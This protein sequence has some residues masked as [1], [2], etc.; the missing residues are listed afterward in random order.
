[1]SAVEYRKDII[2]E[3]FYASR[4]YNSFRHAYEVPGSNRAMLDWNLGL[5]QVRRRPKDPGAASM[6]NLLTANLRQ[7]ELQT[8][9]HS[10][11]PYHGETETVGRYQNYANTGHMLRGPRGT[12]GTAHA[13]DWQLNLRDG[14]HQAEFQTRWRRHYAR[15]QPS[16]DMAME[17]CGR[18]NA[19]YQSS[20]ITPQDRR[21]DRR[22]GA[23]PIATI[24]D[25]PI[26]F[27]RLAGDGAHVG[28]WRHLI[29]DRSRGH[30]TR[31][32]IQAETALRGSTNDAGGQ[33]ATDS[34]S[35]GAPASGRGAQAP[36]PQQPARAARG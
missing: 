16:F 8:E 20:L 13:I 25:D 7:K 10:E 6:P 21:P 22:S 26:S 17:N 19:E 31:R 15:S 11:G 30:K 23:I 36:P 28:Q 5:R 18:D 4:N 32:A 24:R 3:R 29:E 12:S 33:R 35:D 27:N 14:L 9:E 1:M 2:G 34:R